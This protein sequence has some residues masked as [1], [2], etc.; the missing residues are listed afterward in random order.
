MPLPE[1][2]QNAASQPAPPDA[3]EP[4]QSLRLQ[5]EHQLRELSQAASIAVAKSPQEMQLALH[6]L[7]VYQTELLI[8]NEH[9]RQ[10]QIALEASWAHYA[11]F[12]DMAPVGYLTLNEKGLIQSANLTAAGLL[13]VTRSNLLKQAISRFIFPQDR[14]ALSP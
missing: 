8:Q 4:G 14:A 12:Y 6:E 3:G 5:A 10:T 13:G 11:D 9:L 1:P 7:Q 2:Y